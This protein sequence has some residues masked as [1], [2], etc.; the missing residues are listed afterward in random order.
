MIRMI[1]MTI[2]YS[3]DC[4]LMTVMA[5]LNDPHWM[6]LMTVL[7]VMINDSDDPN[8]SDDSNCSECI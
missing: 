3:H 8:D 6:T 2:L 4:A 5:V 7:T 1:A